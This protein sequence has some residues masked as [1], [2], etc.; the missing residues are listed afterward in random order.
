MAKIRESNVLNTLVTELKDVVSD[1]TPQLGG[2]LDTQAFT[3]DGRDVS[4]DGTK[5]DT[6]ATSATA[7]PNAIDNVVE[8]TTPQLGGML[9]VNGN[10]IGDGTLELL[11]F[12]ETASAVNELTV[13]NASTGN[14]PSISATGGDTNID[15]NLTPK[16]YGRFIINGQG[17]IQSLAEKITIEATAATGTKT[18]D[19]LTQALLYYTTSASGDWTLNVRGDGSTALNSI[20]DTGESVTIAHMVTIGGSEYRNSTFQV[21]GSSITPEWQGGEAPTEGNINSID[22]YTYTIIKTA[23]AA[24]TVLG[25]QTQFA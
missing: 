15:L 13:T 19:V 8:D 12:V 14:A 7:N 20:M 18:F 22:V 11:K 16:G 17:A 3:V 4:T 2:N 25:A 6:I 23:N 10:A 9:D 1:T 21:D 5:L 24:F